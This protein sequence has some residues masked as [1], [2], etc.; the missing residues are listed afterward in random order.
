MPRRPAV[1]LSFIDRYERCPLCS[2]DML[3][4]AGV[5]DFGKE[6]RISWSRCDHCELRFQNPRLTEASLRD[7]YATTDYFG[8][9][10]GAKGAYTDF[11]R[12]DPIRIKQGGRRIR[13]IMK[14]SGVTGGRLLDVG[15]ASG[16]FGVAA[17]DAGFDPVCIEPDPELSA[18]GRKNYELTFMAAPM[19]ACELEPESFDVVTA[20]GT[21]S[22]FLHPL[23]SI[24][25]LVGALKPN[26]I[27]ALN[28]QDYSHWIRYFFPRLLTGWN[29]IYNHTDHSF[30]I[31]LGKVG[32]KLVA[33]EL[34][35]QTVPVDHLYRVLRI[36]RPA[37]LRRGII[38]LPSISFRVVVAKKAGT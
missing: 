6:R 4:G 2:S 26:G 14:L 8:L 13:R 9:E 31:L 21:D 28:Y 19:E 29:V 36:N 16:F 17:R 18:Y 38:R 20:W 30:D 32:M 23:H 15:S 37:I 1:Q 33:R 35:W 25:K 7:L 24:E 3:T 11:P 12:F 10:G 34:E 22:L 5:F 27:L